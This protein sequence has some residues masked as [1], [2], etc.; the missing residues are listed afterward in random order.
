M[1]VAITRPARSR[2]TLPLVVLVLSLLF[3]LALLL[4]FPASPVAG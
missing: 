3:V 4:A 1:Y 2:F